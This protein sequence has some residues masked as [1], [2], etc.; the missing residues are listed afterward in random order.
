MTLPNWSLASEMEDGV[1]DPC[2]LRYTRSR[3]IESDDRSKRN[4]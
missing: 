2:S 1:Q 3:F 4:V